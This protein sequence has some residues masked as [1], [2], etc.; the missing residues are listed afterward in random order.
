[1]NIDLKMY[2]WVCDLFPINRS[3]TGKGNRKTLKY[4]SKLMPNMNTYSVESGVEA[5]DWKVPDEWHIDKAY[6]EDSKGNIIVDFANSN[7]HV[8]GYSIPVDKWLDLDDLQK[9]IHSL[10]D[11][12]DAIPYVT[13]YYS[14]TWGFCLKHSQRERLERGVY[15]AVIK[16]KIFPGRMDYGELIIPGIESKEVLLST[17]ICHPSMANNELS[18]PVVTAALAQWLTQKKD[19]KYTYRI[20]FLP[21]TIGS[22][23]YLSKNFK[24]LQKKVIA[25]YVLTCIGDERCFSFVPSRSGN[26]LSDRVAKHVLHHVDP[27]YKKYKFLDRGSDE[28]QYC[29]PGIDLP[30]AS[31]MRSK[32]HEYPEYH[33]SLDNLEF[34]TA[35]GLGGGLDVYKKIITAIENNYNPMY[36]KYC[37]PQLGLRGL[38]S[39]STF[40]TSLIVNLLAYADGEMSL[41]EIAKVINVPVWELYSVSEILTENKLLRNK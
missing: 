38:Y 18:G 14:R 29:S 6:I 15:R 2:K 3:L 9:Y 8:V 1:M 4:L 24:S 31:V 26:T 35:K 25:G 34:V 10:P 11:Q 22:I 21:E 41:L 20:L 5:F 39:D 23:F 32:Y 19:L 13:S 17:Y 37:E 16:S 36:A 28:R 40:K 7:L 12:P 27:G 30:I 33:T